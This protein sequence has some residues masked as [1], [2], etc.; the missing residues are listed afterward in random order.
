MKIILNADDFG[1]THEANLGIEKA[2]QEGYCSQTSVVANTNY[3]DEAVEIAQKHG[4][5]D[6]VGLHINLFDGTP[7]TG[8]IKKLKKYARSDMFDY[9]P[10]IIYSHRRR[11]GGTDSEIQKSWFFVNE[12][13]FTSLCIL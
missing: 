3:F 6:K 4:F 11:T 10:G 12:Y 8:G 5:M 1:M 13:R 9:R 2:M 7:L